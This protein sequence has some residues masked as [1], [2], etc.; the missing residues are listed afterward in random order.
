M[1]S[2][3]DL[4]SDNQLQSFIT[5]SFNDSTIYI[6]LG[7]TLAAALAWVEASKKLSTDLKMPQG[8][9]VSAFVLTI[10]AVIMFRITGKNSRSG[11]NRRL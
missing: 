10:M 5:E 3:R 2:D 8:P 11:N 9:Y 4:V 6:N 7:F 1:P